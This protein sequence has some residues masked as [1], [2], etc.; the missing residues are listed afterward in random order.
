MAKIK[1]ESV[2]V[3][4]TINEHGELID[5]TKKKKFIIDTP[6]QDTYYLTFIDLIAPYFSLSSSN[7]KDLCQRLCSIAEYNTGKID[8]STAVRVRLC[9]E[10]KINNDN[11][12]TYIKMLKDINILKIGKYKGEYYINPLMFLERRK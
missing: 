12:S 9:E 10:M 6:K 3:V 7:A 1:K 2:E 5:T 8:I 4:Q 11:L